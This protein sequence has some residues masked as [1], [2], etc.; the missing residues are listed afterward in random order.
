VNRAFHFLSV[1]IWSGKLC[2]FNKRDMTDVEGCKPPPNKQ[3]T[4][5]QILDVKLIL[6]EL[7]EPV[8]DGVGGVLPQRHRCSGA[9]AHVF[10]F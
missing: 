8:D 3:I 4:T 9:A 2:S 1:Q 5:M 10:A 6:E 7:T